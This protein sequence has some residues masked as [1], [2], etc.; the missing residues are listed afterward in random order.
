MSEKPADYDKFMTE[1]NS[2]EIDAQYDVPYFAGYNWGKTKIYIDKDTPRDIEVAGKKLDLHKALAMHE[3]VEKCH[4]N[5]GYTYAGAHEIAIKYERAFVQD[6]GIEWHDYDMAV[7]KLMHA[8]WISKLESV[9]PDLDMTP[10]EYCRDLETLARVR[11]FLVQ[12]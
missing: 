1:L 3:Y 10:M 9:P 8:N 7:A 2:M 5:Q 11:K 4:I 12:K 6:A